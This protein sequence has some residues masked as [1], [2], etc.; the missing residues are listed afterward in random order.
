[1]TKIK[2]LFLFSIM[3]MCSVNA[4]QKNSF[5]LGLGNIS[6]HNNKAQPAISLNGQFEAIIADSKEEMKLYFAV[7]FS[8]YIK[9][10]GRVSSCSDCNNYKYSGFDMGARLSFELQETFV[11]IRFFTGYTRIITKVKYK[12]I[13]YTTPALED[14]ESSGDIYDGRGAYVSNFFDLGIGIKAPIS[15]R[16]FFSAEVLTGYSL[17]SDSYAQQGL[18]RYEFNMGVGIKF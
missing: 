13:G 14:F 6:T 11:P 8:T 18:E 3:L 17:E 12:S 4:Q 16:I 15:D 7:D 2:S 9:E 10:G 5:T 1:M